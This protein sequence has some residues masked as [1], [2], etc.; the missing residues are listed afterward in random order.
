MEEEGDARIEQALLVDVEIPMRI[1]RRFRINLAFACLSLIRSAGWSEEPGR[2]P[3]L[4]EMPPPIQF[5]RLLQAPVGADA[6]WERFKGK[7]VVMEFW[8]TWCGPCR[9]AIPHLN[10]LAERFKGKP[11]QFIAVTGENAGV[12]ESF[13]K[14]QPINAWI[15]IDDLERVKDSF[16]VEGIP[17]QSSSIP[18]G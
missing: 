17:R 16:G 1:S 7:V 9:E 15:G 3:T 2:V 14:R 10:A 11:V 12:V 8:A 4:N 6:T 5:L 18:A 13:L